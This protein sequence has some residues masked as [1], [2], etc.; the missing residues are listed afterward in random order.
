MINI[1]IN[2]ILQVIENTTVL[3]VKKKVMDSYMSTTTI[4]LLGYIFSIRKREE[5]GRN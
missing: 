1:F 4:V 2:I 5:K 3:L